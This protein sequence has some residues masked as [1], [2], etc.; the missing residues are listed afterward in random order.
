MAGRGEGA[1]GGEGGEG[2]VADCNGV[3]DDVD[4]VGDWFSIYKLLDDMDKD[5]CEVEVLRVVLG[6]DSDGGLY[7]N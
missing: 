6:G 7:S 2:G 1:R 3:R 4:D 5:D